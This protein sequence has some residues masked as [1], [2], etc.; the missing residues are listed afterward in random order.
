MIM[1]GLP[2]EI[3]FEKYIVA[4][5]TSQPIVS[6]GG[7]VLDIMEYHQ[8]SNTSYDRDLCLVRSEV[9]DF[10]KDTQPEEYQK[11]LDVAGSE[12]Q[13]HKSLF[14]RIDRELSAHGTLDVLKSRNG[15]SCGYGANFNFVYFKPD[16]SLN[17]QHEQLYNKNRIG[18]MR[19]FKYST[20]EE[21][22]NLAIDLCIFVNGF[23]VATIELKNA[24][25][26]QTHENAIKQYMKTRKTKGEKSLE[27]K[28]ILVHFACGTEQVYM[29]TKLN[30][31][32]TRFFPFNRFFENRPPEGVADPTHTLRTEYLW[33]DVLR[34]DSLLDLI[35]NYILVQETEEKKFDPKSGKLVTEKITAMIFP[36]YHQ[37]RAVVNLIKD[38]RD[39][40]VGH[41]YLIEH[42][43]GSGKSNTIT[44]LAFRLSNLFRSYSDEKPI[45]DTVFVVTD[46]LV[47][48]SQISKNIR[49]FD[50]TPGQVEY[51]VDNEKEH[52]TAQDLKKAIEAQKK[53]I[54]TNI[55]KF[56][57]ISDIVRHFP[58]R[59]Y[60]V[61]IDEAH[62]SQSGNMA[63]QMRKA[64][65][66][67]EAAE[68][69][70]KVESEIDEETLL[71]NAIERD[72]EMTGMKKNISYF[73]FTATP[74]PKTIELFCEL[75]DGKREPFDL[76]S[77][78]QAIDE[79]FIRDVLENYMSFRRY[80]KLVTANGVV[81]S[82]YEKKKTIRLLSNYVDLQ[83][84]AIERKSRI[85]IEH[86]ASQTEKEINGEARA[87]LITRSRLHAVRYKL[88]FDEIMQE[89]HL[90]YKALVAFSGTVKDSDTNME[91][92]EQ[93]MNDIGSSISIPEALK[94]PKFRILIVAMKYQ[95]GF[96]EPNLHTMFVDKKLGGTSTVQTLSRLNRT[97]KGKGSTMVLD[98]VNDTDQ[99]QE[100]FQQY[101]DKNYMMQEDE[102]NPNTLY[103]IQSDLYHFDVFTRE[104]VREFAKYYFLDNVDKQKVN[105]VIDRVCDAALALKD[106]D[107]DVFRKKCRR[108]SNLYNF[109]SQILTFKDADL[110]QLAP[111]C[112]AL[113]K[114][115]PYKKQNLPYDVLD[116]TELD[117]YKIKYM[118]IQNIGLTSGDNAMKGQTG[119]HDLP[120]APD[121]KELLS[122]IIKMLNDTYGLELTEDDKVELSKMRQRVIDDKELM[123]FF[124]PDND[125]NE[126]K[127]L[128]EDRIDEELLNFINSKLELYT[129]L[130]EDRANGLFKKIF[131]NELY[132]QRVRGI[133]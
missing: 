87:M 95:T 74:K 80:Y 27:F 133:R 59:N 6:I 58:D 77:M 107:H 52:K 43:A 70:R 85:M 37:R 9:I 96:D 67:A 102:T 57:W 106:D 105:T 4:Y 65:S 72:M 32:N 11:L 63:R 12:A 113:F 89:M 71:N 125:R 29:T 127:K 123:T 8:L 39:R 121:E 28:R 76:Y 99:I 56:P 5:L 114:K 36:R 46:L 90:P 1:P 73:A 55:H 132:D 108:F 20:K 33:E 98:F 21:D 94:L 22:K 62:S 49:Q 92:T 2:K 122:K 24:L 38:Q 81:D 45:Y 19:Q 110:A 48:N 61:I 66:L 100:D 64:L 86:F 10:L 35:Q 79:G 15:V 17:A 41:R 112:M 115:L 53:I 130:T 124:N 42:S 128:F 117:S 91:Y 40:G 44:W 118:G 47:L 68:F 97:K 50:L 120:Q 129:K 30:G 78:K 31:E 101:Y 26:G 111:F 60:A 25:T 126:V 119:G 84:T 16:S 131:F 109:L 34:K 104:D 7:E 18:I 23:P 14:E 93:S 82:E 51:I 13:A 75:K 103:D 116:E 3:D 54:V 88:K 83:D 69:D